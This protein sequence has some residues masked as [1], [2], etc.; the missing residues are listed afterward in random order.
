MGSNR[1][2][3]PCRSLGGGGAPFVG[4]PFLKSSP[5]SPGGDPTTAKWKPE[6]VSLV[7]SAAIWPPASGSI[8]SVLPLMAYTPSMVVFLP[9]SSKDQLK[10]FLSVSFNSN[11][12]LP[13]PAFQ[14]PATSDA[15]S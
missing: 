7:S 10:V 9:P 1:R 8:A 2:L 13:E 12:A 15:F 4:Q 5:L 11:F 14:E 6:P 3:A